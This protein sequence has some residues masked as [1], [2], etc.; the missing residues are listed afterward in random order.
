MLLQVTAEGYKNMLVADHYDMTQFLTSITLPDSNDKGKGSITVKFVPAKGGETKTL[1]IP[2]QPNT[3]N[4]EPFEVSMHAS[5][6]KAYKM[7]AEI[8]KWFSSCFGYEVVLAYLGCHRRGVLFEDLKPANRSS[9]WLSP[10]QKSLPFLG[11]SEIEARITFQ[12]CAPYLVVSKTS[13]ADVSA[14]LDGGEEMDITKFRPNIVV[15]GADEPW[16]EDYWGTLTINNAEMILKHNCVRCKSINVDYST[17]ETGTSSSGEALKR[18]QKDRRVDKGAKWSPVFGRYS[19]WN[20]RQGER[21][22][23]IGDAVSVTK[24]NPE[25][26]T[27]TWKNLG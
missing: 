19:F 6:T 27:W 22:F 2:L 12:D 4:L 18:L 8:N 24:V 14:R 20:P 23:S 10:I 21:V 13:L 26:T 3:D 11:S 25:R 5:S 1:N 15:E 16:E 17:A 7:P 9:S